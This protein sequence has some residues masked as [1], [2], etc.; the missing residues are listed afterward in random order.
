VSQLK[1]NIVANFAGNIWQAFMALAFIPLYIKF[2]GIESYGLIGVFAMI[3]AMFG[4]LDMG[5]STTLNREMASLSALPDRGQEMRNT[6]R[7]LEVIYWG[8]AL[9]VGMVVVA[10]SPGVARHWL[11]AGALPLKPS[12]RP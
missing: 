10:I 8:V 2:M 6:V 5:L 7:T 11:N 3:Q 9:L 4:V 12:L 1:R